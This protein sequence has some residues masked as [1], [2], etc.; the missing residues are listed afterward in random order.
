MELLSLDGTDH[1]T[2]SLLGLLGKTA[3]VMMPVIAY[4]NTK[5]LCGKHFVVFD[6][7]LGKDTGLSLLYLQIK[8]V[9]LTL[10]CH[11]VQWQ[12]QPFSLNS[13]A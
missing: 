3:S 9:K 4:H 7:E 1:Q 8:N 2:M 13:L 6:K 12:Q 10:C 5:I 11:K